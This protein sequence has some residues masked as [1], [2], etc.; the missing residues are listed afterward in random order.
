MEDSE[1]IALY[2]A[3]DE[4]AVDATARKY[5]AYCAAVAGNILD[6]RGATEECVNDTWMRCWESIPPQRPRSLKAFAGRITR[7]LAL[8]TLRTQGAQKRGG[9]QVALA[10]DEL[11]EVLPGGDTPEGS[12]DRQALLDALNG[13][14][15]GLKKRDRELFLRR[16]WYLDRV[17]A[18]ARH[19]GMSR[20]AVTTALNRLRQKLRTHLEQ[21]GF[22]L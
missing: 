14:L 20:T 9:G 6:D 8:S 4:R 16:Y 5:G 2:L 7:N 21:E 19:F 22:D 10:L 15:A 11:A 1:I 3:R 13:F 12:L 18:L 17:E